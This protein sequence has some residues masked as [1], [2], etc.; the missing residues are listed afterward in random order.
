[1]GWFFMLSCLIVPVQSLNVS[2]KLN[3]KLLNKVIHEGD[4]VYNPLAQRWYV[5]RENV[6]TIEQIC[7]KVAFIYEFLQIPIG[8]RNNANIDFMSLVAPKA[9]EFASLQQVEELDL[10]F[11]WKFADFIQ[12][13]RTSISQFEQFSFRGPCKGSFLVAEYLALDEPG[14]KC[15][16]VHGYERAISTAAAAVNLTSDEILASACLTEHENDRIGSRHSCDLIHHP[17]ETIAAAHLCSSVV[18]QCEK[19]FKLD[20][21]SL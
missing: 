11:K 17:P 16:A 9:F 8:R 6:E 15:S 1:M 20:D 14:R 5:D 7:P 13:Q 18:M 3:A 10:S 19:F 4:D 2:A 12:E 21:L